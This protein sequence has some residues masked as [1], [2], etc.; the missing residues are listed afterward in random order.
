MQIKFT[1]DADTA[2][3]V[4]KSKQFIPDSLEKLDRIENEFGWRY[5]VNRFPD[6]RKL[7]AE[8]ER[9]ITY[10]S[11]PYT[12]GIAPDV[13]LRDVWNL[14]R[15][16]Q[17]DQDN[18]YTQELGGP[19][20]VGTGNLNARYMILTD[21]SL[22]TVAPKS[23]RK[24]PY[25][26]RALTRGA[27]ALMVRHAMQELQIHDDVWFSCFTKRS[28]PGLRLATLDE[29]AAY[30]EDLL[31]EIQAIRPEVIILLGKR[32]GE[33][34]QTLLPDLHIRTVEIRHPNA[35]LALGGDPKRMATE[36][37]DLLF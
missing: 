29:A 5:K 36:L 25:F 21:S 4:E 31:R 10:S 6:A 28:T 18:E 32:A 23:W 1:I 3:L 33:M 19:L 16:L 13:R 7:M 9:Y 2:M 20:C 12:L 14:S 27:Y 8:Q 35:Y 26:D 37:F 15:A 11:L 22:N 17:P 24:R 30:A 34:Y